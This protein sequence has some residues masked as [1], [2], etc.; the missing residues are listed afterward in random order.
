[1]ALQTA[2]NVITLGSQ[3]AGADGNV[4]VF[5]YMGGYA[6]AIS[7]LGIMYPDGRVSQRQGIAIDHFITPSI[8]GLQA[9]RDEV[10]E[11]AIEL[12]KQ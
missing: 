11:K 2:P 9:G 8:Q 7:G 1:M 4:V 6:T 5:G 10:L 12:A 3:T